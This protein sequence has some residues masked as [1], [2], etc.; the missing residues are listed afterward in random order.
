[1]IKEILKEYKIAFEKDTNTKNRKKKKSYKELLDE[2]KLQI[3]KE[4]FIKY[5]KET[6]KFKNIPIISLTSMTN[7]GVYDKITALGAL[8]LIN[9]ADLKTLYN[10]IKKFLQRWKDE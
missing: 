1:M 4:E 2:E 6:P 5:V 9:K 3:E 7:R 8:A 10:Y